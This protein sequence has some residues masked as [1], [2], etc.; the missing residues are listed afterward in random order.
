MKTLTLNSITHQ[1]NANT[2]EAIHNFSSE[3]VFG[4]SYLLNAPLGQGA[5]LLARII[6]GELKQQAGTI[7]LNGEIYT[8]EQRRHD[9][10]LVR[11]D[12]VKRFGFL[13]QSVKKQIRF[14]LRHT[15]N[16]FSSSEKDFMRAFNLSPERYDRLLRQFSGEGW[17][18]SCAI[19][20]A[21]GKTIFCFPQL[22]S[23]GNET[24][25]SV[26]RAWFEAMLKLLTSTGA[27]VLVPCELSS[28]TASLCDEVI[29]IGG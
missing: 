10:W 26:Y 15:K 9:S 7:L 13:L 3:F 22:N 5:W 2:L 20:L 4:K 16:Q 28:Q 14:G 25:I 18:A 21:N 11:Y 29:D 17:R 27:L 12:E 8:P 24:L 6:S 19:G 23:P 1:G